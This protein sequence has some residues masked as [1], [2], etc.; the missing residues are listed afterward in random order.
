LRAAWRL[1]MH[2]FANHPACRYI[3]HMRKPRKTTAKLRAWTAIVLRQRGQRLGTVM[4]ANERE[5][6]AAAV[7]EFNLTGEQRKR[8]AVR[9]RGF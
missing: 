8:L 2:R 4:A 1:R 5:A 3:L 9:E 6:E 7:V